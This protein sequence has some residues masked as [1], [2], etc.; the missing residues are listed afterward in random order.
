MHRTAAII[1]LF[2]LTLVYKLASVAV[3]IAAILLHETQW[4]CE[5]TE[6]QMFADLANVHVQ[7]SCKHMLCS[8]L[9]RVAFQV[10]T[11]SIVWW[12]TKEEF[13]PI[14]TPCPGLL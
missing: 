11:E 1:V 10:L 6:D 5:T 7:F 2:P 4:H 9:V 3:W 13:L 8:L 12:L 14:G